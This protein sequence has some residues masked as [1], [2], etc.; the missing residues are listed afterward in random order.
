MSEA[1]C[2][3][4]AVMFTRFLVKTVKISTQDQPLISRPDSEFIKVT[5]KLRKI[6]VA[7]PDILINVLMSKI[8]TGFFKFN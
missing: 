5:Q 6:G 4:T 7:L 8:H 1:I 3:V 2:V